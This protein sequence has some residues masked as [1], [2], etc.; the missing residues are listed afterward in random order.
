MTDT[1]NASLLTNAAAALARY[2]DEERSLEMERAV[3]DA[4]L[5]IVREVVTTLSGKPRARRG[6]PPKSAQEP[7][8]DAAAIDAFAEAVE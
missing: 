1:D 4:R 5:E 3:L 2:R 7:Q 6:R 8:D